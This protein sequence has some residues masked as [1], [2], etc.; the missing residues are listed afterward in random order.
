M[1]KK[2]PAAIAAEAFGCMNALA[3]AIGVSRS[4]VWNWIHGD[5]YIPQ[6]MHQRILQAN[7]EQLQ[8][9]P[10]MTPEWQRKVKHQP[11]KLTK[12]DL[13]WGREIE[14]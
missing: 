12:E 2:T 1:P 7:A 14:E 3:E 9:W 6:D 5:G 8:A 11:K 10:R 13:A 4:T